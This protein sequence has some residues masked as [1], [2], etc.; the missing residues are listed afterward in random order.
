MSKNISTSIILCNVVCFPMQFMYLFVAYS[1][2]LSGTQANY[3]TIPV[4][5]RGGP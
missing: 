2:T 1:M 4:T 5:G 3:A